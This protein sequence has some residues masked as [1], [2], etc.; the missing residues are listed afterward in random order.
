[1][2]SYYFNPQSSVVYLLIKIGD[3]MKII[4]DKTIFSSIQEPNINILG[5]ALFQENVE[6]ARFSVSGDAKVN[7]KINCSERLSVFGKL[8]ANGDV[9]AHQKLK[10][11]GALFANGNLYIGTAFRLFGKIKVAANIQT[12]DYLSIYGDLECGG[13]LIVKGNF[14]T[15]NKVKID[16]SIYSTG[17]IDLGDAHNVIKKDLVAINVN[18]NGNTEVF[19]R[20]YYVNSIS[21]NNNSR[22]TE[23]PIQIT[24]EQFNDT[25][26]IPNSPAPLN[27][28]NI[29]SAN[30][31]SGSNPSS[32]NNLDEQ[33][34]VTP[35]K[36]FCPYCGTEVSKETKFCA[37]CGSNLTI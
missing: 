21:I 31:V 18:I 11:P 16:G 1:M 7:G 12:N 5:K 32:P 4:S 30:L 19:G 23:R 14:K 28:S 24:L 35:L 22:I 15:R 34:D 8:I 13:N 25:F 17:T 2:P 3:D 6:C 26:G 37:S 27:Q 33:K 36:N 29:V 10:V 20:I 9:F